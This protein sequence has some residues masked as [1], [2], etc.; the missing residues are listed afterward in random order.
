MVK[1]GNI[2]WIRLSRLFD[3]YNNEVYDGT[4]SKINYNDW[5]RLK[6]LIDNELKDSSSGLVPVEIYPDMNIVHFKTLENGLLYTNPIQHRDFVKFLEHA[7]DDSLSTKFIS[8]DL[9][10]SYID[11]AVDDFGDWLDSEIKARTIVRVDKEKENSIMKGFNFDFGSCKYDNVRMSM[12]GLAIKNAAG[13]YV[14]YNTAA[15]EIVDVDPFNFEGGEF[16]YKMPVA[17]KDIKPGMVVIHNRVPMFVT[18]I[19]DGDIT[20]VDP[21]AGERKSILPTKNMFGFNFVTRIVTMFDMTG[22]IAANEDNPFGNMLPFLMLGDKADSKDMMFAMAM[23]NGNMG[24][25]MN[26]PLM[27]MMLMGDKEDSRDM[28]LPMMLMMNNTKEN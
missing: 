7:L 13:S 3:S 8:V 21:H 11:Q 22:G 16:L 28:M 17:I 9:E 10:K 27:L 18:D 19:D 14:S 15:D 5:K 12:Y 24:N 25:M 23:S 1:Y 26:N 4:C 2:S 20:V 6:L